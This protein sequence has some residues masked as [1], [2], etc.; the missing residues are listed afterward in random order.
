MSLLSGKVV[1]G[2][3]PWLWAIA[4][5]GAGAPLPWF[6]ER[7][8]L[9]AA[10]L[11]QDKVRPDA[12]IVPA[13]GKRSKLACLEINGGRDVTFVIAYALHVPS[14]GR[15]GIL[16]TVTYRRDV[17]GTNL[18]YDLT[19]E[20]LQ[21]K[22]R[23]FECDL[24]DVPLRVFALLPFQ[25]ERLELAAQQRLAIAGDGHAQEA[26]AGVSLKFRV[27]YLDA[28]GAAVV[29]RLPVYVGYR[30]G[31]SVAG[32]YV[33]VDERGKPAP[34]TVHLARR[35]GGTIRLVV[36]SL[37]SGHEHWLPVTLEPTG[38]TGQAD[39]PLTSDGLSVRHAP[40]PVWLDR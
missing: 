9:L 6:R 11:R 37:L 26:R 38:A 19:G 10:A 36:R 15:P 12:A 8:A 31:N 35:A 34:L 20:F 30:E 21:G 14:S 13:A 32:H 2:A 25:V 4:Q 29:G 27:R 18:V 5:D 24:R 16:E 40:S 1:S 7:F 28:A 33:T 17:A 23:P 39:V 22:A 3:D